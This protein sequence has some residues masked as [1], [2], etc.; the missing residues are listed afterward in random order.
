MKNHL[1]QIMKVVLIAQGA[2][3]SLS[4]TSHAQENMSVEDARQLIIDFEHA[5]VSEKIVVKEGPK[6]FKIRYGR[7]EYSIPKIT[8]EWMMFDNLDGDRAPEDKEELANYIKEPELR[9][10]A[11][12]FVKDH[13]PY[14]RSLN[15]IKGDWKDGRQ[16]IYTSSAHYTFTLRYPNGTIG[17][18]MCGVTI[19]R[20]TGEAV[21]YV[22][23]ATRDITSPIPRLTP[24]QAMSI[25]LN[26][27]FIDGQP[28]KI[29]EMRLLRPDFYGNQ[30]LVYSLS[31]SGTLRSD[32]RYS[33]YSV[34][35]DA[36]TGEIFGTGIITGLSSSKRLPLPPLPAG[37]RLPE[38]TASKE[39]TAYSAGIQLQLGVHPLL[40]SGKPYLPV[41]F[42]SKERQPLK[43]AEG[44]ATFDTL[45]GKIALKSGS[46]RYRIDYQDFI[47]D[48]EVKTVNQHMYVPLSIYR[49]A[50]KKAVKYDRSKKAI[51]L[52]ASVGSSSR[53]SPPGK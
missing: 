11:I 1:N 38:P 21:H 46:K 23:W 39:L 29:D 8:P 41:E 6:S 7:R 37:F 18:P 31:C 53:R 20:F 30:R 25:A 51:Y 17:S 35:M 52:S 32:N 12:Q 10:I 16:D 40:L 34:S 44:K 33:Q 49:V 47:S 15:S 28:E 24:D 13:F 14:Y 19:N 22:H 42:L 43:L 4:S 48:S 50:T 3:C 27:L 5:D 36:N 45:A 2:L 26:T 9:K